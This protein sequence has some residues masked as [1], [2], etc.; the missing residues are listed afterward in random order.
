MNFRTLAA[1]VALSTSVFAMGAN[2]A[3]VSINKGSVAGTFEGDF[4]VTAFNVTNLSRSESEASVAN[5]DAVSAPGSTFGGG[6][7]VIS[8]DTFSYSGALD[9]GT[10]SGSNTTIGSFLASG[11]GSVSGLDGGFGGLKNSKGNID[12]GT[13]TAT[14]TFYLFESLSA[15]TSG[16]FNI[17][18]D[19]GVLVL[20]DGVALGGNAGPTGEIGTSVSGFDGGFVSFLYVSTN[21]DP[22]VLRV[23]SDVSPVPVPAGVVLMGTALA[24]FGAM[25]RRRKAA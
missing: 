6:D 7:S 14:T 4:K 18:H 21:S 11:S 20:D 25:R 9:F 10:S 17:A 8:T 23:D 13:G 19:D 15:F 3:T 24:G 12:S 22:S 5:W 16:T 1:A 2:A